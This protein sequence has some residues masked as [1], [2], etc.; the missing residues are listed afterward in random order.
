VRY[1]YSVI[2]F[3]PDPVRGEFIN[4]GLLVGSD[5]SSEWQLRTLENLK[6]ARAIDP[7]GILPLVWT[8]VDSI[9]RQLDTYTDAVE[10]GRPADIAISEKWLE[11][12][13]YDSNNVVQ[14]SEPAPI[15]ADNA[16]E[17]L[18]RLFDRFVLE[19]ETRRFSF[20]KKHTALAAIRR[21]YRDNGLIKGVDFDEVSLVK[22][23]HHRERFDFVVVN[24]GVV[25]LAQAWSFQVPAQEELIE[26][27]K[28]WSWTVDDIRKHGGEAEVRDRKVSVPKDVQVAAVYVP[29]IQGATSHALEE[30]LSA[31][32]EIHVM[33]SPTEG[34]ARVGTSAR[35][36]LRTR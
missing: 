21:A 31:F 6:R 18:Q 8:F 23:G 19:P 2:R 16:E 32:Q 29:P 10:A 9:G 13:C 17:A 27:V 35:E 30:A 3:V 4:V 22:G 14:L 26:N 25:Q 28:A 12:L 5:E 24:G 7:K 20:Q 34:V 1:V 15:S 36:R 33:A 11:R